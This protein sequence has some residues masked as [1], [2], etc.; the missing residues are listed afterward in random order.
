MNADQAQT[1][2]A[3]LNNHEFQVKVYLGRTS[4][5]KAGNLFLGGA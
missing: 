2:M 3:N 5:G 4:S 1:A